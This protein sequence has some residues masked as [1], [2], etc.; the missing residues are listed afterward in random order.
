MAFTGE[1]KVVCRVHSNLKIITQNNVS[2]NS[3]CDNL[4]LPP[5][6]LINSRFLFLIL[7]TKIILVWRDFFFL[8]M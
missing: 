8:N 1:N 7:N 5:F 6:V 3:A 4:V 2:K